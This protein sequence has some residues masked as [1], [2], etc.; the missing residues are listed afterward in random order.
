MFE[1]KLEFFE[2]DLRFPFFIQYGF[3]SGDFFPHIHKGFTELVLVMEGSATHLIGKDTYLVQKG[4]VFV[5]GSNTVHAFEDCRNFKICN[6][7]FHPEFF[8]K[9]THHIKET[10]GFHGLFYIEPHMTKEHDYRSRLRLHYDTYE[11][12]LRYIDALMQEYHEKKDGWKEV[13]SSTF[14]LLV[15]FLSREYQ[16]P[17]L[18]EGRS[19]LMV[20]N[21]VSYIEKNYRETITID[22]L[23]SLACLSNR[24]FSRVFRETYG[25]S[26]MQYVIKLRLLQSEILLKQSELSITQIAQSSGFSDNNYFARQFRTRY[27]MT[28]MEYRKKEYSKYDVETE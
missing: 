22:T 2:K 15:V 4:D 10:P 21:A 18:E 1:M 23:S 12:A 19:L 16:I 20:A 24:Q 28:P 14:M 25:I 6:I 3:H 26:P 27:H 13:I 17:F 5:V 8:F 11:K 7:M 9:W